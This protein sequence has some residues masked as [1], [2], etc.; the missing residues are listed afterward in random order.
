MAVRWQDRR[1]ALSGAAG[2]R[3]EVLAGPAPL[4]FLDAIRLLDTDA[5]FR[6]WLSARLAVAPCAAFRWETP[7][8][9]TAL[10]SRPFEFVLIEDRF[11]DRA[12]DPTAFAA[13]FRATEAS[14]VAVPNLGRTSELIVPRGIAAPETYT[15]LA[16]F[17]RAA[18]TEQ[19]HTLWR[20]VAATVL[21]RLSDRPLWLSTAGAGVA[22]LHVRVDPAPKYYA[23]RPYRTA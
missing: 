20:C 17:L 23:Y 21:R 12:P 10:A 5:A 14:A 2:M 22:W 11:L 13:S 1:E 7:A 8:L 18:P 6:D 16:A 19:I 15:H 4:S 9:S 3:H